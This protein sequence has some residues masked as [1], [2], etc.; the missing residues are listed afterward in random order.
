MET[1]DLK[2]IDLSQLEEQISK[3]LGFPIKFAVQYRT[4][5]P[6]GKEYMM[7]KSQELKDVAGIMRPV[8][9]S[10]TVS[11]FGGGLSDDNTRY[12]MPIAFEYDFKKGG[13]NGVTFCSAQYDFST[14]AWTVFD[15]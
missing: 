11:N 9:I 1:P 5:L 2:Q 15:I 3:M 6:T 12:W 13:S 4:P 10:L 14:K 7:I 8:Y